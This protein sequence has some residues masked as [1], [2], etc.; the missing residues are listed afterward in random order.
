MFL[1]CKKKRFE[2]SYF[3]IPIFARKELSPHFRYDAT[4]FRTYDPIKI[5]V[6]AFSFDLRPVSSFMTMR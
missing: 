5:K 3:T 6:D 2:K 1:N 4:N